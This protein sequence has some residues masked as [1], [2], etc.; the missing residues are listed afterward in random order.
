MKTLLLSL[1]LLTSLNL[2]AQT[3]TSY[4]PFPDSTG[5]YDVEIT[6]ANTAWFVA[7]GGTPNVAQVAR[8]TDGGATFNVS[9]LP[10]TGT[11]FAP[12]ITST[13]ASTAYI[14][15]LQDWGNAV[16]LK[17]T[18]GGQS[19]QNVNTPWDPA[20]SWPDYMHAFSPAKICLIGDPRNGDFEIYTTANGGFVWTPVPGANIPDPLPGEFGFNNCGD[21]AGNHIW[22]G[23]N[24]GR[25]YHST[26]AGNSWAA[27]QTPLPVIGALNFADADHGII[28]GFY[29][30]P[31]DTLSTPMFKTDDGGATWTE[32]TLPVGEIYHVYGVP[33][34]L[35][36]SSILVAGV[37]TN[38][39][40][41]GKN[42][43]WISYDRGDSWTQVSDGEIIGWPEF[44]SSTV[45]W[46]GEWG[47]VDH[48][49]RVFKY[50]GSPLVG[51]L[52]PQ[53]LDAR[54]TLSPNPVAEQLNVR[55][56]IDQP[57]D[58]VLLLNDAQGRLIRRLEVS[59]TAELRQTIDMA[60][61][62]AGVYVLTV[63][64]PSG[65]LSRQVSKN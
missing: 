1:A 7:F 15:A 18:D 34:Y 46:A 26:D 17:T 50:A 31:T 24:A 45:G 27:V 4:S 16:T 36:G 3:W 32:V 41:Y 54:I 23:T 13:D 38:P 57:S 8:T 58:F 40:F 56:K 49:S 30:D 53:A 37:Y 28:S 5:I 62:P 47:P 22:F 12:C 11:P 55:V 10:L 39:E 33:A 65:A 43:T 29:G 6:D 14:M 52:S 59:G 61:L 48:A 35:K 25:L 51:L 20:V 42:Q 44:Y 63:S 64:T 19:W 9:E 21:A 60:A 2:H